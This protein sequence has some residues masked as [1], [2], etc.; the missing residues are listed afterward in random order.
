MKNK[1]APRDREESRDS[2]ANEAVKTAVLEKKPTENEIS[3]KSA[4]ARLSGKSIKYERDVILSLLTTADLT[5]PLIAYARSHKR[6]LLASGAKI[7]NIDSLKPDQLTREFKKL[8]PKAFK[9]IEDW[10]FKS[11]KQAFQA[12]VLRSELAIAASKLKA[13]ESTQAPLKPSNGDRKIEYDHEIACHL[14]DTLAGLMPLLSGLINFDKKEIGERSK[15]MLGAIYSGVDR[16]AKIAWSVSQLNSRQ[17]GR[18]LDQRGQVEMLDMVFDYEKAKLAGQ[19]DDLLR[20]ALACAIAIRT[21]DLV[22]AKK[23]LESLQTF[24]KMASEENETPL[25]NRLASE[26][27]TMTPEYVIK[28]R[29]TRLASDRQ[30]S[31]PEDLDVLTEGVRVVSDQNPPFAFSRVLAARGRKT[32]EWYELKREQAERIFPSSGDL[33][34][35]SGSKYPELPRP[36]SLAVWRT[37]EMPPSEK[38]GEEEHRNKVMASRRLMRAQQVIALENISSRQPDQVREWIKANLS[39]LTDRDEGS[40]LLHLSDGLVIHGPYSEMVKEGFTQQFRSWENLKLHQTS[41]GLMI[42]IGELPPSSRLYDV[43]PPLL[44]AVRAL[45]ELQEFTSEEKG[46]FA[47]AI[48]RLNEHQALTERL[49]DVEIEELEWDDE[50]LLEVQET[51]LKLPAVQEKVALHVKQKQDQADAQLQEKREEVKREQEKYDNFVRLSENKKKSLRAIRE[52]MHAMV[53]KELEHARQEGLKYATRKFFESGFNAGLEE[54]ISKIES[55]ASSSSSKDNGSEPKQEE[56][57]EV[58]QQLNA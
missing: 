25:S 53:V 29:R 14:T 34:H 45:R 3:E 30:F 48:K 21:G 38:K 6:A 9:L 24:E 56:Q 54:E 26:I 43:T 31:T 22:V 36:R 27:K 28:A 11:T 10:I 40:L 39:T 42:H 57:G 58:R 33:I 19:S 8:S 51:V 44:A 46:R 50:Q 13:G 12:F 23:Y 20:L 52:E 37:Q 32:E 7:A 55:A 5:M 15:I 2:S 16:Y 1:T 47:E 35:F 18:E 4:D 17:S 49:R 41:S